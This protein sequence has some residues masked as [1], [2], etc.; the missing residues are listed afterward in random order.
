MS[1]RTIAIGLAVVSCVGAAGASETGPVIVVPGRPGVPVM[2]DGQDATW[3]VIE[4]DW[5]LARP[6]HIAPTIIYRLGPPALIGPA[7][8]SF[9]PKT[10]RAPRYGRKEVDAPRPPQPAESYFRSWGVQ[11]DPTPA[12]IPAPYPTPP[13]VVAPPDFRRQP[14][15]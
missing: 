10:G 1:L 4:G 14:R 9:Y 5:G 11:S 8:S 15:P 3:A 12:T 6:S 13:V 7:N 2:I